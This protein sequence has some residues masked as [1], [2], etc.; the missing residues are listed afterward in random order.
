MKICHRRSRQH[1]SPCA[2]GH[3][4][5]GAKSHFQSYCEIPLTHDEHVEKEAVE[6]E[7]A[8]EEEE[9]QQQQQTKE[10]TI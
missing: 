8:E 1:Y 9:E 5:R 10:K 3:G 4:V 6:V 7:E 2:S